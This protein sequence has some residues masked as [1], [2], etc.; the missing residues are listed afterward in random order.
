MALG[1]LT[2]LPQTHKCILG[3]PN[4]KEREEKKREDRK[5]KRIVGERAG[6]KEEGQKGRDGKGR[7]TRP[8]IEI[9]GYATVTVF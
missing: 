3:G 7:E 9:S 5:R 6:Q 8:P 1:K 4:F 2:A